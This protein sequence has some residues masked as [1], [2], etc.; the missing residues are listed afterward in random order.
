MNFRFKETQKHTI[1]FLILLLFVQVVKAQT[2]APQVGITGTTAIHKDNAIFIDWANTVN[3][4]RGYKD[5]AVPES[6]YA[7]YGVPENAIGQANTS[8]VS[9]GDGGEAILQFN[10]PIINGNGAD[11]A[12]FENGFLQ[13][14]GSEMAFL[15][16]AFVEVSTDGVSYV[17]FPAISNIPTNTQIDGFGFINARYINNLAGKYIQDYGTPFD[18]SDLIPLI[19]NTTVDINNIHFIKIIDAV[20]TINAS[21]ATYDSNN[22]MVNDPYPSAFSSGGFDLNAVGV[23]HNST[24][25]SVDDET[26]KRINVYPN[27]VKEILYVSKHVKEIKIY[28][29]DGKLLLASKKNQLDIH[30]LAKGIYLA[31]IKTENI[32]TT[33]KIVKID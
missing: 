11:F 2:F 7:D 8:M 13:E 12:I 21:F 17:R 1:L 5:I 29:L 15:E 33:Q 16:L 6:G 14:D 23:I 20:G 4:T 30:F 28:S 10:H 31:I 18:L 19:N 9:L 22:N 3:I 25:T 26:Y 24:T 27:P 32:T